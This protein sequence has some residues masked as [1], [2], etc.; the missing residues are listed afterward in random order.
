M[1]AGPTIAKAARALKRG[2]AD[3]FPGAARLPALLLMTD[4]ARLA[5]PLAVL[6]RLPRGAGVVLRH[7]ADGEAAARSARERLAHEL[8][9]ACR[10]RGLVLLVAGDRRLA[11][12]IGADGLHLPE[13]Q[14]RREPGR[15][16]RPWPGFLVTAA[17]H[18]AIALHRAARTGADAAL[19]APV[20]QSRSHPGAPCIGALRFARLVRTSRIPVYALGGMEAGT[21]RRIRAS[22]AAGIAGIGFAAGPES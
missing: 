18:S 6:D 1:S 8:A 21:A 12:A 4:S 9:R 19:L 17:C 2:A 5:D 20:F 15:V 16:T 7:Y 13:W 22:G 3:R 14:L 10:R 11:C